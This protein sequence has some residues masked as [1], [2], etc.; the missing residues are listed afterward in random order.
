MTGAE[1]QGAR[2]S[3]GWTQ[4]DLAVASRLSPSTIYR[5]ERGATPT[6]A[7]LAAIELALGHRIEGNRTPTGRVEI[8]GGPTPAKKRAASTTKGD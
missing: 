6:A 8:G 3:R 4:I 7:N 2:L 5:V 1:I